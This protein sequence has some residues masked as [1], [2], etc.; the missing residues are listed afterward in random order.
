MRRPNAS[1]TSKFN[2]ANKLHEVVLRFYVMTGVEPTV[3]QI[4][5]ITGCHEDRIKQELKPLIISEYIEISRN[6]R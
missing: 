6:L 3:K 1:H 5:K 2:R 4:A